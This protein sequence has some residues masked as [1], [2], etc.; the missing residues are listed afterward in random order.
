[1]NIK[2]IV[3]TTSVLAGIGA[4]VYGLYKFY[5]YQVSL[6][7][8][9]CY[10]ISNYKINALDQNGINMD[11]FIK[12]ENKSDFVIT[13]VGYD[14]DI[15]INGKDVGHI[16]SSSQYTLLNKSITE[17]SVNVLFN[18]LASFNLMDVVSL[19]SYAATDK[20]KFI[21]EVKGTISGKMNFIQIKNFPIDIKMSLAEI[22]A[23]EDPNK[24]KT[25]CDIK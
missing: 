5:K 14:L 1:M 3:V 23:P 24:P 8:E 13:I 7:M 15:L 12:I 9:Y 16:V 10:K 18:P 2:K 20:S 21:V 4:I 19:L 11:L 22:L 25:V 17:I 6:A